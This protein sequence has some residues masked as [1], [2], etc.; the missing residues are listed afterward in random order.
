MVELDVLRSRLTLRPV[1]SDRLPLGTS[2]FQSEVE[3]DAHPLNRGDARPAGFRRGVVG[4]EGQA[5][6]G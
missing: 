6:R 5:S 3:L 4:I 2:P 1:H